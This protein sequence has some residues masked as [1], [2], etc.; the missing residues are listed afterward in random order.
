MFKF[1]N[2][3]FSIIIGII[4]IILIIII[5]SGGV[6]AWKKGWI[7]INFT[8]QPTPTQTAQQTPNSFQK[9]GLVGLLKDAE[10]YSLFLKKRIK[11]TN[12]LY[13]ESS[14]SGMASHCEV[15]YYN[16]K[17]SWTGS[18]G[19]LNNDGK[20]DAAVILNANCGGSGSFRELAIVINQ[21]GNPYYLTSKDLGDRVSIN[22]L[23][24]D[25]ETI[26][27]DMLI[28]GP[29]DGMCCPTLHKISKYKLSGSE[30]IEI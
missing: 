17:I 16:D 26:I 20:D 3:G 24:I 11:L 27:L 30:L 19:D 14:E 5:V 13:S 8:S 9:T 6:L 21:N 2:K 23:T 4:S 12:G 18:F 25:A 28:Q 29:N 10:Y 15:Q 22:Y 7:V 1:F